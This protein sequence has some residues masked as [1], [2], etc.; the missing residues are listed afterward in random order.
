MTMQRVQLDISSDILDKV[1]FLLDNL[2][3]NKVKLK[4]INNI[5]TSPKENRI[6]EKKESSLQTLQTSSMNR[7]WDNREDEAWDEL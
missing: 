5:F 7:T 1:M 4:V 3:K 6:S 2:P